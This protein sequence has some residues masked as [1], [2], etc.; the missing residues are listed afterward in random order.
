MFLLLSVYDLFA[1]ANADMI[2]TD[3]AATLC[4]ERHETAKEMAAYEK[5]AVATIR[6]IQK[7][8]SG[9]D[10]RER[11]VIRVENYEDN[12]GV[13]T[14]WHIEIPAYDNLQEIAAFYT[15]LPY[16]ID[17]KYIEMVQAEAEDNLSEFGKDMKTN[18]EAIAIRLIV[19]EII[20]KITK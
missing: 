6:N 2:A 16:R 9:A 12:V 20:R 18:V 3:C 7:A 10:S 8:A 11:K 14:K 19:T 4:V 13:P 5:L 17:P 1:N 15:D